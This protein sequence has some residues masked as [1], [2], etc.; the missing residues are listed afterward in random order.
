MDSMYCSGEAAHWRGKVTKDTTQQCR[1]TGSGHTTM[2]QREGLTKDG[3]GPSPNPSHK[4]QQRCN[5]T[6]AKIES[7]HTP[8]LGREGA[9]QS[10]SLA[11]G[12]NSSQVIRALLQEGVCGKTE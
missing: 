7:G 8:L 12:L 9:K 2:R 10:P 3:L 1:F 11:L 6:T 5:S 4:R